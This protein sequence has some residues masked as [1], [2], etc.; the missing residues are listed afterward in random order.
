MRTESRGSSRA[1]IGN[2]GEANGSEE[3]QLNLADVSAAAEWTN[4]SAEDYSRA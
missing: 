2:S 3:N 4:L 1:S